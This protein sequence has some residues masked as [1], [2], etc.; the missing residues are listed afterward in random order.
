MLDAE[1]FQGPRA[2]EVH[3]DIERAVGEDNL[4]G[5]LALLR[6][7]TQLGTAVSTFKSFR[8]LH[9]AAERG[10][11]EI[12]CAL[13]RSR[14]NANGRDAKGNTPLHLAAR[15]GHD[16]AVWALVDQGGASSVLQLNTDGETPLLL[17]ARLVRQQ[18]ES[19]SAANALCTLAHASG[20]EHV[21][22][23]VL[24]LEQKI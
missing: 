21:H 14:A 18:P 20:A 1:R 17:A 24:R 8:A 5:C 7:G 2:D 16:R 13:L 11:A 12:I 3:A 15:R 22:E 23:V 10:H 4:A 19:A 9:T 6:W